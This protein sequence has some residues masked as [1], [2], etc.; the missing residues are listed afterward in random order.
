MKQPDRIEMKKDG[1]HYF[2]EAKE[3]TEVVYRKRHPVPKGSGIFGTSSTKGWPY[4]S[5]SQGC[6]PKDRKKYMAD[7]AKLGVPT[8]V[9]HQGRVIFTSRDHQR[10]FC[11]ANGLVN[12]DDNWSGKGPVKPP[13]PKKRPKMG[14]ANQQMS[15]EPPVM[16]TATKDF[17]D[18]RPK[19]SRRKSR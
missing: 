14:K 3:V 13:P 8:A 1:N 17:V 2:L 16:R 15:K 19:R 12:F 11:Q 18:N 10:R 7:M 6:H 5:T 9:D 4:T